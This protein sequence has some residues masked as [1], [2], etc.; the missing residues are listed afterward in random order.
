MGDSSGQLGGEMVSVSDQDNDGI[1]DLLASLMPITEG[2]PARTALVSGRTGSLLAIR[3]ASIAYLAAQANEGTRLYSAADLDGSGVVDEGDVALFVNWYVSNDLNADL[4]GDGAVSSDDISVLIADY[5]VSLA[6]SED[7]G[8][9]SPQPLS[10]VPV[11]Q[12]NTNSISCAEQEVSITITG[13]PTE[14]IFV[15]DYLMLSAVG[16]PASGTYSWTCGGISLLTSSDGS[17]LFYASSGGPFWVQVEYSVVQT[18]GTVC[19][20]AACCSGIINWTCYSSVSLGAPENPSPTMPWDIPTLEVPGGQPAILYA[21]GQ[22][23]PGVYGWRVVASDPDDFVDLHP[24]ENRCWVTPHGT[25]GGT[26]II[27]VA[28][29]HDPCAPSSARLRLIFAQDTDGDG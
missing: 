24:I 6:I 27:E 20:V 21:I 17:A 10:N 14:P 16:A 5:G 18:D 1:V 12:P 28:Y 26:V 9:G 2:E 13:C 23:L 19:T 25:G 8:Q 29:A 4:D 3:D 15:G 7:D 22:P 11:C